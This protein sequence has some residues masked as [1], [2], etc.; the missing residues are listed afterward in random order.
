MYIIYRYN[1]LYKIYDCAC[2]VI[3]CE[4]IICIIYMYIHIID[5]YYDLI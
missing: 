3:L 1:N 2:K 5:V 4:Y